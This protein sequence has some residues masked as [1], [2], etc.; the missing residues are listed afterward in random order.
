MYTT[1]LITDRNRA[2][3]QLSTIDRSDSQILNNMHRTKFQLFFYLLERTLN[4]DT[5]IQQF[6]TVI[7][8]EYFHKRCT[9]RTEN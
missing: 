6:R 4:I 1:P 7:K 9:N 2:T 5:L 8:S 3:Y